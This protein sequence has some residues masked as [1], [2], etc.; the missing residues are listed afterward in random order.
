[1]RALDRWTRS[2]GAASGSSPFRYQRNRVSKGKSVTKIVQARAATASHGTQSNLSRQ[3]VEHPVDLAFVQPVAILIHE[4]VRLCSRAKAT[5][6][7]F[8][9]IGQDLTGRGMQRY[10]TG[11]AKLGSPNGEDAFGPV[12]ILGMEIHASLSRRPVTANNPK[13]Q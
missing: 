10:Q 2:A 6:P 1:M 7:P 9:V 13:K 4:E 12:Q 11:L 5:V 8:G 3:P